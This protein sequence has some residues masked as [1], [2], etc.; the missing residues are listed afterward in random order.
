MY[1]ITA[2]IVTYNTDKKELKTVIENF[3]N[4]NLNV[5]LFISDNSTTNELE[6][7]IKIFSDYKIEYI[8]N[9][10]N[11]GYGWGHNRVLSK[12]NNKS[13]YHLI[14]NSDISF[15]QGI[16]EEL[17]EYME[18]HED[19]GQIMPMVRY[20]NGEIQYLCKRLPKLKDLLLRRFCPIKK[21]VEKN[22]YY[23]EMRDTGYNKIMEV[24]LL[25]GCFM[26]LR[27]NVFIEVKGFDETFFMY[28]EDYDL[29]RRIGKISK[30]I[31]FPKVE[32]IHNHRKSSYKNKKMLYIHIKSGI[33]YFLKWR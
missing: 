19:V 7:Y 27:T 12:I 8:F 6:N 2:S 26:F 3:F 31:F 10:K 17:F 14:L 21:I 25:S 1:D 24:S 4:T 5:K 11:G 32:I 30:L 23:Y 28:F 22:N 9:N 15:K 29:C 18:L 16:L 33:K 20:P 13:K